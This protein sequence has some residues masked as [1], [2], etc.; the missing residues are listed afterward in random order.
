MTYRTLHLSDLYPIRILDD[1]WL[2]IF[3]FKS[4]W[5]QFH[6]NY[7][8]N[9]ETIRDIMRIVLKFYGYERKYYKEREDT[10]RIITFSL[11]RFADEEIKNMMYK[12]RITTK[13]V[14]K[15]SFHGDRAMVNKFVLGSSPYGY[16]PR[17]HA[18]LEWGHGAKHFP[19]ECSV[20]QLII[21]ELEKSLYSNKYLDIDY[22]LFEKYD[23]V[24]PDDV[25]FI[26][27]R[28]NIVTST[29]RWHTTI[30]FYGE[31]KKLKKY[32]LI[33]MLDHYDFEKIEKKFY[34]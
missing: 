10:K 30:N 34:I 13:F 3:E 18:L 20:A 29:S 7:N 27:T 25:K 32:T 21:K 17:R 19:I 26:N 4:F 22:G 2:D 23:I 31:S 24:V 8:L 6:N 9:D 1:D 11:G 5:I 33:Q 12:R 16:D 28:N 15:P 14:D